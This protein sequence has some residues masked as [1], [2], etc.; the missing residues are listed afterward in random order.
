LNKIGLASLFEAYVAE[1]SASLILPGF[2]EGLAP[3]VVSALL[4][5]IEKLKK[6][7]IVVLLAEQ[8]VIAAIRAATKVYILSEGIIIF[9]GAV[10]EFLEKPD[11]VKKRLLV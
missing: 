8:N 4:E 11:L 10:G 7:G 6:K 1:C 2:E 9:E 5:S 3:L